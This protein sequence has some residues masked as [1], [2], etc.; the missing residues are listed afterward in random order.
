MAAEP[1]TK[2][3]PLRGWDRVEGHLLG[4]TS[5]CS[6]CYRG[7]LEHQD[8]LISKLPP[9]DGAWPPPQEARLGKSQRCLETFPRGNSGGGGGISVC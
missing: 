7:H 6:F 3:T 9:Q 2:M 8:I 4:K 1:G 5:A